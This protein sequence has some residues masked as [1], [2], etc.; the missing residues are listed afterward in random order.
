MLG[1]EKLLG[2]EEKLN[3]Y[4]KQDKEIKVKGGA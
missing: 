3:T 4:S 1:K 2:I